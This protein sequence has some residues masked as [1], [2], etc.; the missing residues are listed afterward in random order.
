[1][2]R[3]VEDSEKFKAEDQK[4]KE[5]IDA[6]NGLEAYCFNIKST[7]TDSN[8]KEKLPESD[9]TMIEDKCNETIAWLEKNQMGE[10]D[11][12]KDKQKELEN[13][14]NPI[15]QKLYGNPGAGSCGAQSGQSFGGQTNHGPTVEEVD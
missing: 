15:I 2:E 5:R 12:F 8:M 6:K 3:M 7:V 13:I 9:R 4:Q 1:M 10:V 11:E 14:F